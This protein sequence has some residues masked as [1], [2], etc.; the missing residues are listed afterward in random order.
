M[1]GGAPLSAT[2]PATPRSVAPRPRRLDPRF[3]DPQA[4]KFRPTAA[5]RR[6]EAKAPMAALQGRRGLQ[7]SWVSGLVAVGLR[8]VPLPPS[9]G[10]C[11]S[12]GPLKLGPRVQP[13]VQL[14]PSP[15]RPAPAAASFSV[16]KSISPTAGSLIPLH[17]SKAYLPAPLEAVIGASPS[18]FFVSQPSPLLYYLILCLPRQ[19]VFYH[20]NGPPRCQPL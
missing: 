17:N 9:G 13:A 3:F 1:L 12:V 15:V 11:H 20:F 7:T 10:R 5:M 8:S 19:L 6:A 2:S 18:S 4:E 16:T 14:A